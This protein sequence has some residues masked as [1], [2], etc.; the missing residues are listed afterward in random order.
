[1]VLWEDREIPLKDPG[2]KLFLNSGTLTPV[3]NASERKELVVRKRSETDKRDVYAVITEAGMA[4]REKAVDI[5]A[6]LGA[7][8]PLSPEDVMSLYRILHELMDE[9]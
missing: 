2:T 8:V 6:K 1:M 9:L 7:C 4:L 3:L 5:P